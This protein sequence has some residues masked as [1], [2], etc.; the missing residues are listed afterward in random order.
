MDISEP[1]SL[2]KNVGD[3]VKEVLSLLIFSEWF[4][5]LDC[6]VGATIYIPF[7][8]SRAVFLVTLFIIEKGG[9]KVA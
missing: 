3:V 5:T 6:H 1:D 7:I 2:I 4:L 9:K 8:W